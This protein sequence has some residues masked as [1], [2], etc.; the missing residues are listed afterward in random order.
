MGPEMQEKVLLG[1][2]G[3]VREG[4]KEWG[5]RGEGGRERKPHEP[6]SSPKESS[7]C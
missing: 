1:W 4:P 3:A 5:R 7:P 2:A 6:F